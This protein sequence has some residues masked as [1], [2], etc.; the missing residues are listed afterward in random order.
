MKSEASLRLSMAPPH[1][2]R[3]ASSPFDAVAHDSIRLHAFASL[4]PGPRLLVMGGVH[5]NETSG[6]AGI[7]RVLAEFAAGE[8]ALLRGELTLVPVA[9][10][11][12]RRRCSARASATSTGCS[13]P[14]PSRPTTRPA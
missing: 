13:S 12:A 8:L 14:R 5:G 4:N 3:M 11:L 9:N 10:P 7:E 2:P 1:N 6:T